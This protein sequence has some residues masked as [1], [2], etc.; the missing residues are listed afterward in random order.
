VAATLKVSARLAALAD[1]AASYAAQSS[2]SG[3][4]RAY[5]SAWRAYAAWCADIGRAPLSGDPGLVALYLT[6]RADGLAVASLKVARAAIVAA[7]RLADIPLDTADRRL[8]MVMEGIVRTK[9]GAGTRQAAPA[10][11]DILRRLLAAL[12]A[13]NTPDAAAPALRKSSRW[14]SATSHSSHGAS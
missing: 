1:R 2:G 3:T 6:E 5:Q 11:P 10:V 9:A 8:A 4:R 7:H 12:P 14:P 13:P